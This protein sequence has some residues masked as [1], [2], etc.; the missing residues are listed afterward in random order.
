[1]ASQVSSIICLEKNWHLSFSNSSRNIVE[2]GALL[3]SFYRATISLIQ[4]PDKDITHTKR[5]LQANVT[6]KHRWENPPQ[7]INKT[8]NKGALVVENPP[9][10][11]WDSGSVSGLRRFPGG[12]NGNPLQYSCPENSKDRGPW[13]ATVHGIA[14]LGMTEHTHTTWSSRIHYR[15]QRWL[16]I[17]KASTQSATLTKCRVKGKNWINLSIDAGKAFDKI[18]HLFITETLKVH[19]K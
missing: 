6:D 8:K 9:D 16:N 18:Q 4:K 15:L 3:N 7:N 14:E 13:R 2:R 1:M 19:V 17:H 10:S 11:T 12:G 5:N